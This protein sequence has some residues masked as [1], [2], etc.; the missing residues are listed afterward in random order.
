MSVGALSGAGFAAV[1]SGWKA[2]VTVMVQDGWHAA[3][4][5]VTVTGTFSAGG[6]KLTCVTSWNGTCAITGGLL[7]QKTSSV[8]FTIN[9]LVKSGT[10]YVAASNSAST[11][12]VSRPAI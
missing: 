5:G 6:S 11:L 1:P 2:V 7:P 10:P 9:S 8:K 12:T 4:P 3:V